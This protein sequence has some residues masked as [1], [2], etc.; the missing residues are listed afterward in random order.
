MTS[1]WDERDVRDLDRCSA[2]WHI[3]YCRSERRGV[4]KCA[5]RCNCG[6]WSE[7]LGRRN[8]GGAGQVRGKGDGRR[9]G[10]RRGIG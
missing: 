7:G 5:G 9:S 10:I 8:R 4:G 1:L 2:G 6:G 3:G